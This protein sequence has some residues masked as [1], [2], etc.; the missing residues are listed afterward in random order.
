MK[1]LIAILLVMLLAAALIPVGAEPT[2]AQRTSLLDLS[3][4]TSSQS[5]SN[6]GW[7]FTIQTTSSNLVFSCDIL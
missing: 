3:N 4:A 2:R 7:A 5:N 1:K 6:E